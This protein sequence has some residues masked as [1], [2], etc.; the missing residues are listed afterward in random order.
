MNPCPAD[1]AAPEIACLGPI[2]VSVGTSQ[3]ITANATDA[4]ATQIACTSDNTSGLPAGTHTVTC[5]AT[6]E[7]NLRATCDVVVTVTGAFTIRCMA[8]LLHSQPVVEDLP[9]GS[10]RL[11]TVWANVAGTLHDLTC[12]RHNALA[13]RCD[14]DLQ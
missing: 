2:T 9:R 12:M 10:P 1:T 11:H 13:Q 6:D 5:T 14:G 3:A 4:T 8:I 7:A